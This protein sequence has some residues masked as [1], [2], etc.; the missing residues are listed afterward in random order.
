MWGVISYLNSPELVAGFQRRCGL[1][2]R[3]TCSNVSQNGLAHANGS[4]KDGPVTIHR[5]RAEQVANGT[6]RAHDSNSN[7]KPAGSP[8]ETNGEVSQSDLTETL[9]SG[10]F[11]SRGFQ[12]CAF[13]NRNP[14]LQDVPVFLV[15][16]TLDCQMF[17]KPFLM[18]SCR[19]IS[20]N[21]FQN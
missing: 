1:V 8:R 18:S 21:C 7:Y 3:D 11:K 19:Y 15:G 12:D 10:E 9:H 17:I 16:L 20:K 5:R 2:P 4:G 14:K 6:S 13:K